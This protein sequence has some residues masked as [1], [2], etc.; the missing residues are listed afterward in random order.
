M[1]DNWTKPFQNC[2]RSKA[3]IAYVLI[4]IPK[5]GRTVVVSF[6]T[7]ETFC[8]TIF[9]LQ[10]SK[11]SKMNPKFSSVLVFPVIEYDWSY[12]DVWL[13]NM[14]FTKGLVLERLT[15]WFCRQFILRFVLDNSSN[16][17]NHFKIV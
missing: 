10:N 17:K 3:T 5:D 4:Q 9:S 13:D 15:G 16:Q 1:L 14:L 7:S 6:Y 12:F 8:L 2:S 11:R